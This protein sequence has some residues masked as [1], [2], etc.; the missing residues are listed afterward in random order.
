MSRVSRVVRWNVV[1]T[2][3]ARTAA[4][5]ITGRSR[6][7]HLTD[8]HIGDTQLRTLPLSE[9][10]VLNRSPNSYLTLSNTPHRDNHPRTYLTRGSLFVD[11]QF[12]RF[13]NLCLC[14]ATRS[15]SFSWCGRGAL[16]LQY[17]YHSSHLRLVCPGWCVALSFR[18]RRPLGSCQLVHYATHALLGILAADSQRLAH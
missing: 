5:H 13:P 14:G 1:Y 12:S 10:S 11:S 16:G 18:G 3:T 9:P 6:L 17:I 8:L 15:R 2:D 7:S 4:R